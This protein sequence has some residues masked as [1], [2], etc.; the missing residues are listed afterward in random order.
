[1]SEWLDDQRR[2]S[3]RP[4]R[5]RADHRWAVEP[6]VPRGRWRRPTARAA[7]AT[8]RPRARHGP[9]HGPRAP[10]HRGGGPHRCARSAKCSGLC[11]TT[12]V[13]GAPFYVMEHVAGAVL[14]FAGE[15]RAGVAG[16]PAPRVASTSSTCSAM[17][18]A[19]D[20]DDDRSRRSGA[21]RGLRGT[22]DQTMDRP[23]G[24]TRRPVSCRRSTRSLPTCAANVPDQQGVSI[25][26]GD[27]RFGNVITDVEQGRISAV[28][29]WELCTLGDPLAD[30]GL[31]RCVLGRSPT[32]DR[33]TTTRHRSPAS[34]RSTRWWPAMP[35]APAGTCR[36]S[37]TTSPSRSCRLAVISEGVYGRYLH[38]AMGDQHDPDVLHQF[39]GATEELAERALAAL[40]G[41][42]A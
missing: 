15:G 42:H 36:A 12:T 35:T 20:I 19:A 2:R 32:A 8:A 33:V 29:D 3:G 21:S 14:D 6:D 22:A 7:A 18:H 10:D 4:V 23:S 9:R 34:R 1:M 38:G 40:E 37:I 17:L 5:V 16:D 39:S 25:A 30:L 26:H 31:P 41:E 27:Y 13:N 28:L 11:T 24:R